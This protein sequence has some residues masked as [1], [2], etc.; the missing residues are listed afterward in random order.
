M[1]QKQSVLFIKST[2]AISEEYTIEEKSSGDIHEFYIYYRK[3]ESRTKQF[4]LLKKLHSI[5]FKLIKKKRGA[6]DILHVHN[7]ITP[8]IWAHRYSKKNNIPWLLSEHWS[9]Y[10]PRSGIFR[11][12]LKWERNL[13]K[14]YSEKAEYT[15]A[16][17]QFLLESLVKNHIGKNH[18]II[19]NVVEGEVKDLK[20]EDDEIRILNVSDMVDEVKNI[21]GLLD[22]F[23]KILPKYPNA[24]LYLVG[25]GE[26][27]EKM[28][29]YASELGLNDQVKFFG[30]LKNEEVLSIYHE[31]DFTVINSRIE[32]FSVVAA[33]SLMAGKPVISTRCGGVQEFITKDQG[34]LIPVDEEEKLVQAIEKM[35]ESHAKYDP[36]TLANFAEDRFSA[37]SVGMA[38]NK[39]Y[40]SLRHD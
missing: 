6:P 17:S 22:A 24:R 26:D 33:E 28:K 27:L 15:I 34:L 7:L 32:T 5:G 38:L 8:A 14:W 30:R 31:V 13:W 1:F 35:I 10:T 9:G 39:V 36:F 25:G 29:S 4:L 23:S 12:K 2:K 20:R 3:P 18:V 16:V 19:P 21:S 40:Q 37:A 11:S